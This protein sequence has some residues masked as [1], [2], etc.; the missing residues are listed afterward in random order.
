M[1]D[2]LAFLVRNGPLVLFVGVFIEQ[3]GLPIPAA[4]LLLA[5]GALVAAGKM[6]WAVAIGSA[7]VGSLLADLIW[8]QLGRIRGTRI[9]GFLCR[10]SLEPDSCIRSTQD[11]FLHHGMGAVVVAKFVPGLSTVMPPLAA[12]FRVPLRRF[13]LF[14]GLG[15]L[16]YPVCVGGLGFLFSDQVVDILHALGRIGRG[17]LM[18]VLGSLAAYIGY[19]YFQRQRRLRIARITV[20]ELRRMQKEGAPLLVVDLRSELDLKNDP[21]VIAGALHFHLHDLERR[22]SEIPRDRDVILYCSCPNEVTSARTAWLLQ[23]R[24]IKRV[25]PLAGGIEAWRER[26]YPVE[27]YAELLLGRETIGQLTAALQE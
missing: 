12:I 27:P 8:Y 19:K 6:N 1:N 24:G 9:L 20:D 5:A 3:V 17:G 22:H 25:R 10:I 7:A 16:L 23:K 18:V 26:K 15:C 2:A 14:D 11:I 4:P 13:L 21:F